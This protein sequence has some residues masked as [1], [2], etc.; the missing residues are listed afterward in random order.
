MFVRHSVV[1]AA[2]LVM[3]SAHTAAAQS[4]ALDAQQDAQIQISSPAPSQA[5][6]Q[7]TPATPAQQLIP[8]NASALFVPAPALERSTGVE[9][10]A[11]LRAAHHGQGFAMMVTGGALLLAG[12]LIGDDIGTVIAVGGA[13]IGAYGLYTYLK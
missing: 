9:A 6:V 2:A 13:G 11:E 3:A 5:A 1:L 12:L 10:P 4:R 7:A 8:A